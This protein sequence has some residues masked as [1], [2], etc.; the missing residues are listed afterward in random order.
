MDECQNC[1]AML[2]ETDDECRVCGQPVDKP[3]PPESKR[4][5]AFGSDG[6]YQPPS[7][8]KAS[9]LARHTALAECEAE[10]TYYPPPPLGHPSPT[11]KPAV[12]PSP[13][14]WRPPE[15]F[16]RN[17]ASEQTETDRTLAHDVGGSKR[18]EPDFGRPP[19]E[20]SPHRPREDSGTGDGLIR[21][22]RAV[23]ITYSGDATGR[24]YPIYL[25]H[26]RIG[27]QREELTI[28]LDDGKVSGWHCD[29]V[30][31]D[32]DIVLA[33]LGSFNKTFHGRSADALVAVDIGAVR[34]TDGDFIRV[35]RTVFLIRIVESAVID[36]NWPH[37]EDQ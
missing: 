13:P 28:D 33:D 30:A 9:S 3:N 21:R 2:V 7:E 16:V 31:R 29:V 18:R 36:Q 10:E 19:P 1:K 37:G 24:V 26:N 22:V 12:D 25:G 15:A 11:L 34:L 32:D 4:R 27:R 35:G 23:L 6:L 5:T 8:P 20:P 17:Q 14:L